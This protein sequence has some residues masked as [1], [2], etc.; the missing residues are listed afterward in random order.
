[1]TAIVDTSVLVRYLTGDPPHQAE[2]ARRLIESEEVIL[3]PVS[4]LSETAY[5]LGHHYNTPRASIV[6]LLL[7]LTGRDNVDVL[8]LPRE[9]ASEALAL[10]RPSNRVSFSD[11]LIWAAARAV[12]R[13]PLHTFDQR[14]PSQDLAVEYLG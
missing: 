7:E 14:F 12:P 11:A 1:M 9:L 8:D 4:A 6:D 13:G 10:C 2:L 5:T 3:V